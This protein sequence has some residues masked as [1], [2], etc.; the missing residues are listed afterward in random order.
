MVSEN[1]RRV[2]M[3]ILV[4]ILKDGLV[5]LGVGVATG[6]A[7]GIL[8]APRG[9]KRS[10]SS[11]GADVMDAVRDAAQ[12]SADVM[13]SFRHGGTGYSGGVMPD[14]RLT[15]RIRDEL[16]G[17]A[18]WSPR[19]DVTTIDGTVYVR[20]REPDAARADAIFHTIRGLDGVTDVVDELRRE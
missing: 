14:E 11:L 18:L 13:Q 4:G 3:S 15:L 1:A 16:E 6:M 5:G 17:L 2:G 20:G 12:I 8:L 7:A 19:I 10:G 9:R